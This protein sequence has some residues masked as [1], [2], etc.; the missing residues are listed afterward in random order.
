VITP[1][2]KPTFLYN[3]APLTFKHGS[4]RRNNPTAF[5]NENL[6]LNNVLQSHKMPT[7][8][9]NRSPS[10][11][12]RPAYQAEQ[13]SAPPHIDTTR[14]IDLVKICSNSEIFTP[15]QAL[16]AMVLKYGSSE[17]CSDSW[18]VGRRSCARLLWSRSRRVCSS[19]R[20]SILR[21]CCLQVV[22]WRKLHRVC[23][24]G[25]PVLGTSED[26]RLRWSMACHEAKFCT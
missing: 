2:L 9:T 24:C 6:S 11:G 18:R 5:L 13:T 26:A 8:S 25:I 1:P 19:S 10:S 15:I 21:M 14:P 23:F 22:R 20:K 4:T 12:N 16:E 7:S 3:T 17:R